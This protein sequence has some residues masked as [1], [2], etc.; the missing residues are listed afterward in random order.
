[1]DLRRQGG[2]GRRRRVHVH[3]RLVRR[4]GPRR[5]WSASS[6]RSRRASR[7]PAR[8]RTCCSSTT[9]RLTGARRSSTRDDAHARDAR[10]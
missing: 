6:V 4:C 9:R 8:R 5:T 3:R 2:E 10:A 1:M 7:P